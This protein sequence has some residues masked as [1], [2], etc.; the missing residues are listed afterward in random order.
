MHLKAELYTIGLSTKGMTDED[1]TWKYP[2]S[3]TLYSDFFKTVI[4]KGG[5]SE[6][7]Q[8]HRYDVMYSWGCPK[9][10]RC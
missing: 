5:K 3:I 6:I 2:N 10:Q 4:V 9:R 8:M 1:I 7:G